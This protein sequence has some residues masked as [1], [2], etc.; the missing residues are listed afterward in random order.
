MKDSNRYQG[1]HTLQFLLQALVIVLVLSAIFVPFFIYDLAAD[2]LAIL[3]N[4]KTR[5]TLSVAFGIFSFMTIGSAALVSLAGGNLISIAID[6]RKD[7][8]LIAE[9]LESISKIYAVKK[10]DQKPRERKEINN[11]EIPPWSP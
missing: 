1:L 7:I 3:P 2:M 6:T 8:R 9:S 11:K 10:T 5:E 4:E